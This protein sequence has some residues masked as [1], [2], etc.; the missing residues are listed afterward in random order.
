[1][2]VAT[3][4]FIPIIAVR[5]KEVGICITSHVKLITNARR[6]VSV[7]RL[8]LTMEI[9]GMRQK[10][11]SFRSIVQSTVLGKRKSNYYR[12]NLERIS[13]GHHTNAEWITHS[14][15]CSIPFCFMVFS[16]N[17]KRRILLLR[18]R[19]KRTKEISELLLKEDIRASHRGISTFLSRYKQRYNSLKKGQWKKHAALYGPFNLY[20]VPLIYT[21]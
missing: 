21:V 1:M 18:E 11:S 4:A 9:Y 20:N 14:S 19:G 7:N 16:D 10:T 17:T 15:I 2:G 6:P 13:N 8:L 5:G 3:H 12:M